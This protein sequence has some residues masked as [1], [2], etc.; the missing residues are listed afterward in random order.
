MVDSSQDTAPK[1][2]T[3]CRRSHKK[4]DKFLPSCTVCIKKGRKCEYDFGIIT[5]STYQP[6]PG[7]DSA[8]EPVK[9]KTYEFVFDNETL[10]FQSTIDFP[11]LPTERLKHTLEYIKAEANGEQE[12]MEIPPLDDL[13]LTYA[14]QAQYNKEYGNHETAL[15]LYEKSRS[16]IADKFDNVHNDI[17]AS[18]TFAFLAFYAVSDGDHDRA[19]FYLVNIRAFLETWH[20]DKKNIPNY[21]F[22]VFLYFCIDFTARAETDMEKIAKMLIVH[23]QWL[24]DLFY[25]SHDPLASVIVSTEIGDVDV[26]VIQQDVCKNTDVFEL[27]AER[28][29]AF[30]TSFTQM[31]DRLCLS[32]GPMEMLTARRIN[33]ILFIYGVLLQRGLKSGN[34]KKA[35]EAA[36]AIASITTTPGFALACAMTTL[37]VE[38]AMRAHIEFSQE[39]SDIQEQLD[40]ANHLREEL[41]TF[42]SICERNNYM[43]ARSELLAKDIVQELR[44]IE[45]IQLMDKLASFIDQQPKIVP[46]VEAFEISFEP[47]SLP[48]DLYFAD[49]M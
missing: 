17:T 47:T 11:L 37:V 1:A 8:T 12:S 41:Q 46:S 5:S 2:C 7:A 32:G 9:K 10:M 18:F 42:N 48:E 45:D 16:I 22:L 28:T 14:I 24:K 33:I 43:S 20:E 44:R 49:L 29:N 3:H 34:K 30:M 40:I 25:D 36:D 39:S 19:H 4:C 35:R 13:A 27:V 26:E 23:H 38:K 21:N 6:Y 15:Y 31:Y